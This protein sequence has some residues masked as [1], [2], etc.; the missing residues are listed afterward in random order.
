[1]KK[2][3]SIL[4]PLFI[5]GLLVFLAYAALNK[6]KYS[7]EQPIKVKSGSEFTITLDS[8]PTTGYRW[9]I[10]RDIDADHV[11][12]LK[13]E[14]KTQQYARIGQGGKQIFVFEAVK[15]GKTRIYLQYSRP[16]EEKV[17]PVDKKIY[18]IEIEKN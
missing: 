16:W 9:S 6:I 13:N 5:A 8:N 1:M 18:P 3:T 2:I 10:A 7:Q 12:L 4:V 14:Y 15:A 17:P 11:K